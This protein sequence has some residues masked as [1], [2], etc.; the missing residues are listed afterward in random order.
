MTSNN[1]KVELPSVGYRG[2]LPN[3]RVQRRLFLVLEP[4]RNRLHQTSILGLE[5]PTT[6][7]CILC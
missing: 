3:L 1:V 7:I 2:N 5:V 4:A 6:I